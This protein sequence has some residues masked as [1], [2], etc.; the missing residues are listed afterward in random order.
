MSSSQGGRSVKGRSV[1]CDSLRSPFWILQSFSRS[2]RVPRSPSHHVTP[3]GPPSPPPPLAP[4]LQNPWISQKV[5]NHGNPPE[6]V[7]PRRLPVI[8]LV[9][10]A[11]LGSRCWGASLGAGGQVVQVRKGESYAHRLSRRE[12]LTHAGNGKFSC[13]HTLDAARSQRDPKTGKQHSKN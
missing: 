7:F 12:E 3:C 8:S 11:G 9:P 13:S 10:G 2:F 4:T 5:G 6:P 1:R